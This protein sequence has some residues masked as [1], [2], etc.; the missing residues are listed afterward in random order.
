[1]LSVKETKLKEIGR[2]VDIEKPMKDYLRNF[3]TVSDLETQDKGDHTETGSVFAK[4][5]KT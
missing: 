4:A 1:M 3:S 2:N 5:M